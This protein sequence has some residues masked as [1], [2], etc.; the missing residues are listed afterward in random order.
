M[1]EAERRLNE[2]IESEAWQEIDIP[3]T[4]L[5]LDGDPVTLGYVTFMTITE[6]ELKEWREKGVLWPLTTQDTTQDIKL[7]ARTKAPGDLN[8]AISYAMYQVD[9]VLNVL[10]ALCFPFG[11]RG[12]TWQIGI[13]GKTLSSAAIPVR[14]N[15][16][17][18]AAFSST[19]SGLGIAFLELRKNVLAKLGQPQWELLNAL[20]GKP[21]HN[22]MESKLLSGLQWLGE[23]TKPDRNDAKFT[24]ICFALE[25]MIGGEPEDEDLKVRGITAMLAERAAFL[26][27]KDLD[28]RKA[29]DKEIR[30]YYGKRGKIVHEGQANI[31]LADLDGFGTLIRTIALALLQKLNTLR[32][33]LRSI[34]ALESWVKSQRYTLPEECKEEKP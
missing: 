3:I 25:T 14:I 1:D 33:Q 20:I 32:E 12:D 10:R 27:G 8:R 29:I 24:K 16:G 26:V 19:Q 23:S 30:K 9:S 4:N 6:K 2:P 31:S 17:K 5:W 11:R 22:E 28:H 18:F 15:S 21:Q 7:V 13:G 34:E